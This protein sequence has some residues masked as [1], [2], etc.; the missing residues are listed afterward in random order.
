VYRRRFRLLHAVTIRA[1]RVWD[2]RQIETPWG[3]RS[4]VV[5]HSDD[6]ARAILIGL[7]PGQ[8]LG[9]HQVKE[10]AFL[11]VV[12][13]KAQVEAGGDRFTAEPG[14]LIRFEP[15]ERRAVSTSDG[16]RVLL[17]LAPWPGEGHYR[18]ERPG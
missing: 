14:M 11:V 6:E 10:Y 2:L 4:P 15:D 18:G 3:T 17:L 16:A 8:E 13:G 1:V 5:L 7:D 9:D 12:E